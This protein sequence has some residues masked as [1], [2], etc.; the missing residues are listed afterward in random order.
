MTDS[1]ELAVHIARDA[2]SDRWYI[3]E[4][5]V[6][7]LWLEAPTATALIDRIMA[8]VP[9]LIELNRAPDDHRALSIR[10]VFD[11]AFELAAA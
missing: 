8:A 2:A 1:I 10:P 5:D 7:G 4:S 3:T 11:T 6:P 9:E